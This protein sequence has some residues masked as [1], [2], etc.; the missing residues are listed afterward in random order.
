MWHVGQAS[1]VASKAVKMAK[2]VEMVGM[3]TVEAV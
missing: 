3:G 1:S 2:I